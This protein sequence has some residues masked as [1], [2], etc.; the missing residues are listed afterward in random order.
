MKTNDRIIGGINKSSTDRA[1]ELYQNIVKGRIWKTDST[2]AEVVKLAENA[3]RDVQIAFAN[4]LAII[5]E[6]LQI[7]AFTVIE[8][9]NHHPRVE[10]LQPGCGVG[11][12][13]LPIDPW[14]LVENHPKAQIIPASRTVNEYMPKHVSQLAFSAIRRHRKLSEST[15]TVFG[16][17]YKSDVDDVREA[18]SKSIVNLLKKEKVEVRGYDKL[19]KTSEFV[20]VIEN[21]IESVINSDCVIIT[22]NHSHFLSLDWK[23]LSNKMRTP[24]LIDC[25]NFFEEA[26]EGF[27]YYAVGKPSTSI[28]G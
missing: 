14:F 7:N 4:E 18:P 17:A 23:N 6:R 27:E 1:V 12:H 8:L 15:I 26:P 28:D 2:T 3:S 5:C 13:C 25:S 10:I 9:A 20:N 16:L 22:I 11:G 21:P 24:I 19:V